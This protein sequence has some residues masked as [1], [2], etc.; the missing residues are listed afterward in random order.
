MKTI[1][2]NDNHI[3]HL[4]AKNTTKLEYLNLSNNNLLPT[5]DIDQLIS[6]KH[7]WHVLVNVINNDPLAQMQYWTAVRNI[8]DDTNEVTIDLSGLNL[9]TQPPGLQNFTS[10][11]LDNNQLTHFDISWNT[12]DEIDFLGKLN[13]TK[14]DG[15]AQGRPLIDTA[16]D[17]SEVI[18]ALAP[19]TN[20]HVAVKA[21]QA[22]GEITGREHTHLALHK[23]DEKI[24]FRDIQAQP[25]KII[26]S[27]TWSGLESDHV[28]YNAGYT[29][30][31]ELI[32]WRTLSGRQQL[33]QDHPWMRAFGE[34]LVAYRPPIDTRSVSEMRQIPPNGFPEKALNFLTPHQKWGIHSTYSENLLMLTL[35]RGGP[36][37][38]ISE[39]DAR[40]LTIVDNDWVEV[41]N[42][43]GALTARAVV[44]QRVP[45][46]MT[47][48]YHAQERI[49]NIPG[50]EVT[51]MRGGIHNSVTRVCPKPTHMIGGYAQL[52]WGFNY[53]GTVGSNRDE[54]IMIRKMKNVNWLDDEGRDQVQEAKK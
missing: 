25:R 36:I 44:S 47:M 50:S 27:P 39:T 51:G 5:N 17:A 23:E 28:S 45:P 11:N 2:L 12:Q 35:S 54:F 14:R 40:E 38:W 32:P 22:L 1:T 49:M 8:I 43:N 48:M 31:H 33:Y 13:Y 52:A 24:R 21:W 7:L 46:G 16:I 3:A 19:E 53:Y 34:S 30:V 15:P 42:A 29:N 9:T 37:V 18:L 10:I 4:N 26:S 41:F 20:G 6:S